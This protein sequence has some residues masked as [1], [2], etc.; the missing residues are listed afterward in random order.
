M[1]LNILR[2]AKGDSRIG[3]ILLAYVAFIALGMPDGLLGVAWPSIR[4]GFSIP[5]DSIGML[6]TVVVAG[7]MTSSFLS[8]PLIGR[9]GVGRVLAAKLRTDWGG[10]DWLYPCPG[11]VD[12]GSVGRVCRLG[13]GSD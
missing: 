5:L 7:Y 13:G 4:A 1:P 3:L 8:G 10:T 11:V 9:M 2:T 6:I 12:D